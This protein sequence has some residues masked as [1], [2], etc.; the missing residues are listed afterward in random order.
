MLGFLFF[1]LESESTA[2]GLIVSGACIGM[3]DVSL[4]IIGVFSEGEEHSILLPAS[5]C[6]SLTGLQWYHRRW[7][8]DDTTENFF[9]WYVFSGD[10]ESVG[11]N[12]NEYRLDSGG[13]KTLSLKECPREQLEREVRDNAPHLRIV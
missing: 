10:K 1:S 13:G 5:S 3:L 11:S 6:L 12:E 7:E 8:Q 2:M 9:R 4:L